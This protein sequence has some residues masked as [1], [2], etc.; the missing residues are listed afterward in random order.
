MQA[1]L[2]VAAWAAA[3][4]AQTPTTTSPSAASDY[5]KRVVAFL[6]DNDVVTRQQLG[7][8]LID[9]YGAEKLELLINRRIIEHA[10]RRGAEHRS[11]TIPRSNWPLQCRRSPM[12]G[13][14]RCSAGGSRS[15]R[16]S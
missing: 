15:N 13:R 9:R 8:Y 16:R 2:A 6:N 3:V 1:F 10:C 12:A 7:E 14:R 4:P 11:V 5:S